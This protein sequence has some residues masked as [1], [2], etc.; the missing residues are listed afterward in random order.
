[1]GDQA[2]TAGRR[3]RLQCA[4]EAARLRRG[5]R[6]ALQ[7][8]DR[9]GGLLAGDMLALVIA[10]PR[11]DVAHFFSVLLSAS[12][13]GGGGSWV[14]SIR[15]ASAARA[16]PLSIASAAIFAPSRRSA[17]LSATTS[18]AAAFI[19]TIS[20]NA[21]GAPLRTARNATALVVGSSP[22]RSSSFAR[23][24][25]ASS[26]VISKCRSLPPEASDT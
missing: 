6:L 17:A 12:G 14:I 26:G 5:A 20:R 18:A 23:E 7:R 11:Q 21:P 3:R 4:D 9:D 24:R 10:E 16:L 15:R 19:S 13:S 8:G 1:L 2:V 25:P 22:F